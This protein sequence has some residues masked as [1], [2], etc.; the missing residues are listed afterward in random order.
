MNSRKLLALFACLTL[1][2][3][4][5]AAASSDAN[6]S[7]FRGPNGSGVA[8]AFNPPFKVVGAQTAWKTPLPRGKSSPVLWNGRIFLTG[9]EGSRL[10][11]T[12][13]DA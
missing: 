3:R 10:V 8:N 9:V 13:L 7:Q 2:G 6:W 12:A 4:L 1:P 5:P 11:T